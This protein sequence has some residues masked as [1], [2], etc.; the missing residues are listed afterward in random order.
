MLLTEYN[1]PS[2]EDQLSLVEVLNIQ[3]V[4]AR[5]QKYSVTCTLATGEKC[6]VID[7]YL[8]LCRSEEELAM[9]SQE[10]KN[11]ATYYKKNKVSIAG[12]LK[13]LSLNLCSFSRGAKSLLYLLLQNTSIL[14]EQG[15]EVVKLFHREHTP[16]LLEAEDSEDDFSDD[17]FSDDE[18]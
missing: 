17:G 12:A 1:A 2:D 13:R 14:L 3:E 8:A 5:L 18:T 10:A 4:E 7:A 16:V 15:L 9:L 11:I 6:V